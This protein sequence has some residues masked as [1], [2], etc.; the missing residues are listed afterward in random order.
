M[1]LVWFKKNINLILKVFKEME[2][3][4]GPYVVTVYKVGIC[5]VF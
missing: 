5:I 1:E 4:W 3:K 2:A